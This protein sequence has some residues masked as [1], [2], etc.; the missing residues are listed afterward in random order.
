[1]SAT[2]R[3]A[4]ELGFGIELRRGRFELLVDDKAVGSIDNH[5][6]IERPLE[7]GRHTVQMRKGR[8]SSRDTAFEVADGDVVNFRCAGGRIW[9]MYVASMVTPSLAITLKRD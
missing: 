5:E 8:Y 7:A 4:H 1:M 6:R 9:P 3:V 2:L